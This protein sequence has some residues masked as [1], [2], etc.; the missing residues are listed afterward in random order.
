MIIG[1]ILLSFYG[2]TIGSYLLFFSGVFLVC[3]GIHKEE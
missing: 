3:N 2:Y 1:G